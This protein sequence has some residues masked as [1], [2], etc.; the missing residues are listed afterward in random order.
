MPWRKRGL[1]LKCGC[2]LVPARARTL[3]IAQVAAGPALIFA[4]PDAHPHTHLHTP[5]HL[6][7]TPPHILHV[8]QVAADPALMFAQPL[9][10]AA[11]GGPARLS[12]TDVYAE[13]LG[14]TASE[15]P[16]PAL[17]CMHGFGS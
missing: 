1:G 6:P 5:S 12:F 14:V 8:A 3:H 7:H 9:L 13:S 10:G 4:Q 15:P 17:A 2:N 11:Q 16:A